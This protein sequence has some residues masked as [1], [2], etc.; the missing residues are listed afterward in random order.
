MTRFYVVSTLDNKGFL[1]FL[2]H[3]TEV[4]GNTSPRLPFSLLKYCIKF[5][6]ISISTSTIPTFLTTLFLSAK[7]ISKIR[8]QMYNHIV[9]KYNNKNF[10]KHKT[11]PS[12]HEIQ[13]ENPQQTQY[14]Y[15]IIPI[16]P[17]IQIPNTKRAHQIAYTTKKN[18]KASI[19][20]PS[21]TFCLIS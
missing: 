3:V 9:S 15:H 21:F 1:Y 10:N 8:K 13:Q 19:N 6:S 17:N 5:A 11:P 2:S 4:G 14:F 20:F 18:N 12:K 16:F 7:K